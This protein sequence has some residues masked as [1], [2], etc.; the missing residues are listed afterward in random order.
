MHAK[1][2]FNILQNY[3]AALGQ[4]SII[5]TREKA[6]QKRIEQNKGGDT[7]KQQ[8][9]QAA[10]E[11]SKE[12]NKEL[13]QKTEKA[14]KDLEST[15]GFTTELIGEFLRQAKNNWELDSNEIEEKKGSLLQI[16]EAAN[17]PPPNLKDLNMRTYVQVLAYAK[18]MH[19]VEGKGNP[20]INAYKLAF[21]LD[22]PSQAMIYL[23]N[24]NRSM[25]KE[26]S[27]SGFFSEAC[28]IHLPE[29][30]YDITVWRQLAQRNMSEPTFRKVL[31]KADKIEAYMKEKR[32]IA[33]G[34]AAT[35]PKLSAKENA[36]KRETIRQAVLAE[37]MHNTH[38]GD[39]EG[40]ENAGGNLKDIEL[41]QI[42]TQ[43]HREYASLGVPFNRELDLSSLNIFYYAYME[44]TDPVFSYFREYGMKEKDYQKFMRLDRKDDDVLIPDVKIDG[45]DTGYPG[46]YIMKVPVM[47][48][49]QAARAA[50]LGKITHNCQS[51]SGE[52]GEPCVVHGLTDPHGGFYV[53]CKG[54]VNHP[55]IN[56]ELIGQCW[57]WR[58]E[59]GGIV[60]DSIELSGM[61]DATLRPQLDITTTMFRA[62]GKKLV[63]ENHTSRVLSGTY[64]GFSNYVLVSRNVPALESPET[65]VGY[66]EKRDSRHEQ[67]ILFDKNHLFYMYDTDMKVRQE[68]VDQLKIIFLEPGNLTDSQFLKKALNWALLPEKA[69]QFANAPA[70]ARCWNLVTVIEHLAQYSSKYDAYDDIK[71][72]LVSFINQILSPY[73]IVDLIQEKILSVSAVDRSLNAPLHCAVLAGAT[74]CVRELLDQHGAD[75]N[76]SGASGKTPLY[77]AIE[78]K[79]SDIAKQL[80]NRGA[81]LHKLPYGQTTLLHAAAVSGLAE[82][83]PLLVSKGLGVNQKDAQEETPLYAA[84]KAQQIEVVKALMQYPETLLVRDAT[85]NTPLH[86]AVSTRQLALIDVILANG[87]DINEKNDEGQTALHSAIT[88][89]QYYSV[90]HLVVNGA[91]LFTKDKSGNTPL[92][93]AFAKCRNSQIEELV[94]HCD[95]TLDIN[96]ANN[97]GQTLLLCA[98]ENNRTDVAIR[99]IEMGADT[100]ICD[101]Q[102]RSPL[103]LAA[104]KDM[105]YVV[106]ALI[107]KQTNVNMITKQGDSPL[108][109]A[110]MHKNSEIALELIENGADFKK[111]ASN[112][113]TPWELAV[114][115]GMTH[116]VRKLI[117]KGED[118]NAE[119]KNGEPPLA[120]AVKLNLQQ[121]ASFLIAQGA[122]T[123]FVDDK[124]KTLLHHA[125]FNEMDNI[126]LEL[127]RAGTDVTVKDKEGNTALYYAIPDTILERDPQLM[128]AIINAGV[129]IDDKNDKGQTALHMLLV[130]KL[131]NHAIT[132]VNAGA[133]VNISHGNKPNALLTVISLVK[134]EFLRLRWQ[135]ND[136]YN[137]VKSHVH[138]GKGDELALMLALIDKTT[139]LDAADATG[140]TAL[141]LASMINMTPIVSKLVKKG[142]SLD[143]QNQEGNTPLHCALEKGQFGAIRF[144]IEQG[145][146]LNITNNQG[147]TALALI[148]ADPELH[149]LVKSQLTRPKPRALSFTHS[150]GSA[151][152][153]SQQPRNPEEKPKSRP[154]NK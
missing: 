103:H 136:L 35:A 76:Q 40:F 146:N 10:V 98:L 36:K 27:A 149:N 11:R 125:A 33:Q 56:D 54:D 1:E 67:G 20:E 65:P 43:L 64:F 6:I 85:G 105:E 121:L 142:A 84:I 106:D 87:V 22:D 18:L 13:L 73:E 77:T 129:P 5:E 123:S 32:G 28:D 86:R 147:Q 122:D 96:A 46:Y 124:N 88:E 134:R 38:R 94:D 37:Y 12:D 53:L 7:E 55:D 15:A 100:T 117:E 116:V 71:T 51:L 39:Q 45:K 132:L 79:Q 114:E 150:G 151:P 113:L 148:E 25:S 63:D 93:L 16:F 112:G 3:T 119:N 52:L 68:I 95:E 97:D 153:I 145:A 90:F 92:H 8:K 59:Q 131:F 127:I 14:V 108:H 19:V 61:D 110:L 89:K 120:I 60:F 75:I 133:D 101:K 115:N 34:D 57:A 17:L 4:K 72:N 42:V 24:Q 109:L 91:S 135:S 78:S 21:I 137:D 111:P 69:T 58:G 126:A 26:K 138:I 118:I 70:N 141:H 154:Q 104:Q 82:M 152:D 83:V 47:D 31:Q 30:D 102:G 66:T 23:S 144:L 44:E 139:H 9:M 107:K 74:V 29:G 130:R 48:E 2:L 62:F 49:L 81:D 99:L 128:M 140:M 41:C 80:I 143:S 50:C